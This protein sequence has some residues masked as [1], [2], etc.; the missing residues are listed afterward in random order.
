MKKFESGKSTYKIIVVE[1]QGGENQW[2]KNSKLKNCSWK[3]GEK[4]LESVKKFWLEN[5]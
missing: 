5:W 3:M 1:R 4:K 2:V